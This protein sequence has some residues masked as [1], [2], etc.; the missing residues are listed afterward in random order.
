[1]SQNFG[2]FITIFQAPVPIIGGNPRF[3][4]SA[5]S[6]FSFVIASQGKMAGVWAF[7]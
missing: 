4:E 3:A 5:N 7:Q 2:C 6:D 1:V